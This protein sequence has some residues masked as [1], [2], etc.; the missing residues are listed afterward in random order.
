MKY[1]SELTQKVYN[2]VDELTKAEAEVTKKKDQRAEDAKEVTAA[3]NA[4]AKAQQEAN[5]KLNKFIN[6]Y[7]SFKTT[8]KETGKTPLSDWLFDLFEL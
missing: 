2:S 8:I 6:K 7:G 4:A 3:I 5:D 1:Y